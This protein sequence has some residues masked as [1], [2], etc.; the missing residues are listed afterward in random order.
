MTSPAEEPAPAEPRPER[1]DEPK[2][3]EWLRGLDEAIGRVSGG[4]FISPHA[5]RPGSAPAPV[6]PRPASPPAPQP[7]EPQRI[8]GLVGP[9]LPA[10]SPPPILGEREAQLG[11]DPPSLASSAVARFYDAAKKPV[12]QVTRA[13]PA[14]LRFPVPERASQAQAQ[15]QYASDARATDPL[16]E[17]PTPAV[18]WT[19]AAS[20]VPALKSRRRGEEP[21]ALTPEEAWEESEPELASGPAR[22]LAA[23]AGAPA[24]ARVRGNVVV[25][26][27]RALGQRGL[28]ELIKLPRKTQVALGAGV[29]VAAIAVWL[30]TP[31]QH[32]I[33]IG[34]LCVNA[35][36]LDGQLVHI[37]GTVGQTFPVGGGLAFYL[38]QRRDSIAVF[39]SLR[40]PVERER[41]KLYGTVSTG[42]LDGKPRAAVF[43]TPAPQK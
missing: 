32:F 17:P 33:S 25:Q 42:F 43:E 10:T 41:I 40:A 15:A 3:P 13:V 31:K 6:L 19:A 27:L 30:V 24:K 9:E 22:A 34:K 35:R 20:S 21:V 8:E 2:R 26:R 39:T 5:A 18:A 28:D 23:P 1:P 37:R 12:L 29:V 4:R 38:H 11:V 14:L 16:S 36:Q 7:A